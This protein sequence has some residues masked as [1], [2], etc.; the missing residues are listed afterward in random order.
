[1]LFFTKFSKNFH[2]KLDKLNLR[3]EKLINISCSTMRCTVLSAKNRCASFVD[4][5]LGAEIS[6]VLDTPCFE[7]SEEVSDVF[8]SSFVSCVRCKTNNVYWW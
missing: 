5:S 2:P 1:M 4:D 3:Q 8:S 7:L 6:L